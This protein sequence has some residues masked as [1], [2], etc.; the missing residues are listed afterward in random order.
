[1][2]APVL[3]TDTRRGCVGK[4]VQRRA[5]FVTQMTTVSPEG[6][7]RSGG[8]GRPAD[9][10]LRHERPLAMLRVLDVRDEPL[11]RRA[12]EEAQVL[13]LGE[14]AAGERALCAKES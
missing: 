3:R 14:H 13:E 2:V 9:L 6:L 11:V 5:S 10:E 7:T 12:P 8:V 1:M 4:Y